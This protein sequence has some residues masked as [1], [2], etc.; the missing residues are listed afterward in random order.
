MVYIGIRLCCAEQKEFVNWPLGII[1]VFF[2]I[3][4]IIEREKLD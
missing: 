4:I 1:R 2:I 3:I